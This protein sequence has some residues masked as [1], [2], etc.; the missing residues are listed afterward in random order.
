VAMANRKDH[1]PTPESNEQIVAFFE[2][3]LKP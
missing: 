1:T 3:W 2:Q